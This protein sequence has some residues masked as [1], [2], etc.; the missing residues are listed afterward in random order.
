M[1]GGA[2]PRGEADR[3]VA[4]GD[5]LTEGLGDPLPRPPRR[6]GGGPFRGERDG[7]RRWRGFAPLLAAGLPAPGGA[8]RLVNLARSGARSADVA[9]AQ[10]AAARTHRPHVASVIVGGNDTLRS[11]FDIARTARDLDAVM[12]TLTAEGAVVL[13]ACLPDPGRMLRLPRAVTAPLAR[14]MRA[15]NDVVHHLSW[16]HGAVHAHLADHPC[17]ADRAAWSVDRLHPSEAGHRLLAREFHAGLAA[18]GLAAG[19]PPSAVPDQPPPR[20]SASAWWLAT[21]GTR[22][23]AARSTDLLPGLLRLAAAE[24]RHRVAGT[25]ETLERASRDATRAALRATA[26][27]AVAPPAVH[28]AAVHP[29][30]VHPAGEARRGEVP[31]PRPEEREKALGRLD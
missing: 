9:G 5:S 11:P 1:A 22:W 15:L 18:R 24:T 30:P 28:P 12:A 19:A 23:V 7:Q 27:P 14:R 17:V 8:V 3:F 16:R 29:P 13:T 6:E 26:P 25:R 2:A 21:R 10:L 4:L 31:T 20:A